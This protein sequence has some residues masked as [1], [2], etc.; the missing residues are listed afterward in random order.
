M[1]SVRGVLRYGK[2]EKLAS[3]ARNSN[4]YVGGTPNAI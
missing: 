3:C 2:S 4:Q 1:E